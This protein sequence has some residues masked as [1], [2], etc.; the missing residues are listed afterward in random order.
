MTG[1]LIGWTINPLVALI[2]VALY[3]PIEV[4]AVSPFL[5]KRGVIFGYEALPNS[6]SDIFFGA[7]GIVIGFLFAQHLGHPQDILLLFR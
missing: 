5:M 2:L 7:I 3:E 6:L 4:F 1:I